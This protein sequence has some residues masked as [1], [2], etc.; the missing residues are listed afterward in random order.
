VVFADF[1]PLTVAGQRWSCTIFPG[2]DLRQCPTLL[3]AYLIL[4]ASLRQ[5]P[6]LC[7]GH[8][9]SDRGSCVS[10]AK[11]EKRIHTIGVRVC[12]AQSQISLHW[13]VGGINGPADAVEPRYATPHKPPRRLHVL[14]QILDAGVCPRLAQSQERC[15]I[16]P[17]YGEEASHRSM[18]PHD[19]LQHLT[20]PV[21]RHGDMLLLL[22][23]YGTVTRPGSRCY[24][25]VWPQEPITCSS[26]YHRSS[27]ISWTPAILLTLRPP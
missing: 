14:A 16:Q 4:D 15:T 24:T 13:L 5:T 3:A 9:C 19:G 11:Q 12:M 1:V 23:P 2:H 25:S 22:Q 8:F 21:C 27:S 17:H 10:L 20:A 7:Q 6:P 18:A 26:S